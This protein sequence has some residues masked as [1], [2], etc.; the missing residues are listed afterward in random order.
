MTNLGRDKPEL[1]HWTSSNLWNRIDQSV[2]GEADRTKVGAKFMPP[3]GPLSLGT[4]TVPAEIIDEDTMTI[5]QGEEIPL[6]EISV[7][8]SLTKEQAEQEDQLGTAVTLATRAANLLSQAEDLLL[9]QGSDALDDEFFKSK[10]VELRSKPPSNGGLLRANG[11]SVIEVKPSTTENGIRYGE[12]TTEAVFQGYSQLQDRGHYGPYA[13]VLHTRPYADSFAPLEKTL[14]MPADRIKELVTP[15]FYGTGT[16]PESTGLLMSLGGN[17]MD[18]VTGVAPITAFTQVDQNE[19]YS[20][21]VYE[22]FVVRVKDPK[23]IVQFKF[24]DE[25]PAQ[26]N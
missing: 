8:F 13:L 18:L 2:K 24:V 17:S 3:Y 9:Y 5:D 1:A 19:R 6:I 20:F 7:N 21:R 23:A 4:R 12:K 11:N 25:Q 22:R 26:G 10:K 14:I 16:L 15:R